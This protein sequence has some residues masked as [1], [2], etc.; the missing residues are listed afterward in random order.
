MINNKKRKEQIQ[1]FD[2]FFTA[3]PDFLLALVLNYILP[4]V[5]HSRLLALLT[6]PISVFA[7]YVSYHSCLRPLLPSSEN[8]LMHTKVE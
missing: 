4:P 5:N 6:R 2:F 1:V 7:P 3:S 8:S